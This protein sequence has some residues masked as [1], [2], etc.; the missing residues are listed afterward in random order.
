MSSI[1]RDP[2]AMLQRTVKH[3][4]PNTLTSVARSA[5]RRP[6]AHSEILV[7][8]ISRVPSLQVWPAPT[9]AGACEEG[10]SL[11]CSVDKVAG[12]ISRLSTPPEYWTPFTGAI[13]PAFDRR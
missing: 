1:A 13:R 11:P 12:A 8:A 5:E 9:Y 3:R 4:P 2:T 7:E 10:T 6:R